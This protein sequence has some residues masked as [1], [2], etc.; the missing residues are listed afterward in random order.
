MKRLWII[1]LIAG[2][3]IAAMSAFQVLTRPS[4]GDPAPAFALTAL[5]GRA[6]ALEQFRGRPLLL[7]FWATWCGVCRAEFPALVRLA[8]DLGPEGLAVLAISED[9]EEG[10]V[11]AFLRGSEGGLDV[12]LDR[13]GEVA[14]AYRSWGVPESILIAG[15]GIIAWR[16]SGAVDWDDHDVR[17]KIRSLVRLFDG[18]MV[19]T[20]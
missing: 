6:I 15:D 2:I 1:A 3:A 17:A 13:G 20:N 8:R 11:R 16:R 12:A 18:S 7:H 14:D 9:R 19:P 10:A 4:R 5:D